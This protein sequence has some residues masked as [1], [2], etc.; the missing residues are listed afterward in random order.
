MTISQ[1]KL[2][3]QFILQPAVVV[4]GIYRDLQISDNLN[5]D[6]KPENYLEVLK[7]GGHN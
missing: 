7:L 1:C 6:F 2:V 4:G 5:L 3:L